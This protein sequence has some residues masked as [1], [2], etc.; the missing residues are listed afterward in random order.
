M[1]IAKSYD[2]KAGMQKSTM[3]LAIG[4]LD[5][6]CKYVIANPAFVKISHIANLNSVIQNI[7]PATYQNDIEKVRRIEFIK[8]AIDARLN[9]NLTDRQI[10]ISHILS[11]LEF[12]PNF[13]DL[14]QEIK[15][16]D[17]EWCHKFVEQALKY[18][19]IYR[20]ADELID[21]CTSIK[22]TNFEHR[23]YIIPKFQQLINVLG[24]DFRR[25]E[26]D[27]N[28]TDMTFSLS[29]GQFENAI[30]RVYETI[31]N[32]NRRLISG[33][34]GLNKLIGGGFEEERV[35]VLLGVTGVGK[36]VTLLNLAIQL[37]KYNKDYKPKDPSKTPCIVYLT[38]ENTVVETVTRLFDLVT[39]AQFG[40]T[41]YS[42]NEVITK[43]K[44]EGQLVLNGNSPI[45]LVIKY[46]PNRSVDTSYCYKLYDDLL[47][48]GKE[49]ICLLQDHLLRIRSIYGNPEPR[50]ELGDV[51]NEFKTFAAQKQISVITN[52][53]LNREA[54]KLIETN[55]GRSSQID[56][57]QKMGKSNISE[58]VLILNNTD[59]AIIINREYDKTDG[60][61]YMG[62]NAIKM[63]DKS[64]LSYFAQPFAFGN[65]IRLVE[66]VNG[67]AMYK[68]SVNANANIMPQANVRTSSVNSMG[69]I[70]MIAKDNLSNDTS[71]LDN[72]R[73]NNINYDDEED[74]LKIEEVEIK[75]VKV[76]SPFSK[77]PTITYEQWYEQKK[78][79][80]SLKQDLENRKVI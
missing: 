1:K 39:D 20:Y 17:V 46:K 31:N 66:D 10:I 18:G 76:I 13:I 67:P 5:I 74:K 43:L 75:H 45:D 60:R 65:S 26:V 72:D 62:F 16:D 78:M 49:M 61:E 19:F 14:N 50:F 8:R 41:N 69:P 70:S 4:T 33:M 56:V 51:V 36:S 7:D 40:M 21:I 47:A 73:Y 53:H 29:Q 79:M 54:M 3:N 24:S 59:V 58:S 15:L 28:L 22:T 6:L 68:T 52:F 2:K 44:L 55:V 48:E 37:K 35:Y 12:D 34:Q 27:D 23:A 30:T 57:T 63:R 11:G 32:P 64:Q 25:A 38:M 9:Y 71:F 80:D 77:M 42:L